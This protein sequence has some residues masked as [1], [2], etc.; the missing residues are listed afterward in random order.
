MEH[1]KTG[2]HLG[3]EDFSGLR[4]PLNDD[5][6]LNPQLNHSQQQPPY[7]PHLALPLLPVKE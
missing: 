4:P 6:N 3:L 2:S 1:A 5:D 7:T